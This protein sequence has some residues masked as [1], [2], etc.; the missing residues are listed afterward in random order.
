MIWSSSTGPNGAGTKAAFESV[1]DTLKTRLRS[2]DLL[3]IHTNN[4]GGHNGSDAYLCTYSGPDYTAPAFAAK[5][6]KLPVYR[7]LIVMMEQ[8]HSG[9]FNDLVVERSTAERTSFAA[10]CTEHRSSIGGPDFD[11]FARDWIAALAGATPYGTTLTSNPDVS[12]DNKVS[13]IEAFAYADG[14]HHSYDSPVFSEHGEHAGHSSLVRRW[15][16]IDVLL[17]DLLELLQQRWLRRPWREYALWARTVLAPRLQ[18]LET[19]FEHTRPTRA[20]MEKRMRETI[21]ELLG[22]GVRPGRTIPLPGRMPGGT[23][24]PPL[25]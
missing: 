10:A 8:C 2:D 14:I 13:S 9:G 25:G 11:P 15:K 22:N 3:L 24:V 19:E 6:T 23:L 17:A 7:D 1:L 16:W 18:A 20:Q 12:G 4:H 5:L 21:D